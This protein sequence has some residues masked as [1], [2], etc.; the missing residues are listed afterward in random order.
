MYRLKKNVAF[1][2]EGLELEQTQLHFTKRIKRIFVIAENEAK[3]SQTVLTPVHLLIACLIEKTGVLGEISLKSSLKVGH[4]REF[5]KIQSLTCEI[6]KN[7]FFTT[8]VTEEVNHVLEQAVGYMNRYNQIYLNEGHLI[9]ALLTKN[10]LD[11]VLPPKDKDILLNLGTTARDLITY[12]GEYECPK[13]SFNQ[14]KKIEQSDFAKL[15]PFVEKHFA[16]WV[17][18]IQ[19]A[20][21]MNNHSIYIALDAKGEIIGFAAFDLY[22]NK[23]CY[24]GPMGVANSDRTKG[25]GFSLLHHCL[26]EMKK[27]G[28]EYA[29]I[30]GAGPIEFY[31][32]A[33][34][35]VVIPSTKY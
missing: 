34:H 16:G 1:I 8:P 24:F 5:T 26:R 7:Q 23:K 21:E 32:K 30:G 14:V 12:L 28:Y 15:I 20:K 22:K 19:G 13:L 3:S 18:T 27:I 33:C 11:E 4:L 35:A 31:E 2:K 9:K 25:I 17:Q 6:S 29:V 10:V